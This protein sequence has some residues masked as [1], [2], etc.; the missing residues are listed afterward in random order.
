MTLE[1]KNP[2]TTLCLVRHGES[3]WNAEGRIQGQLDSS[4]SALGKNQ[5]E[6]VAQRLKNESWEAL[7]SSD[8][9]RARETAEVIK[10]NM[11]GFEIHMDPLLRERSFGKAE[12]LVRE[13]VT[14]RYPDFPDNTSEIGMETPEEL[15]ERA[16]KVFTGIR[17]AHLGERVIIVTHG[18]LIRTF[19]KSI[20]PDTE[21]VSLNNTS[22]TL[23]HWDGRGWECEYLGDASH[24]DGAANIKMFAPD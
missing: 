5:A 10:K 4:L 18:G 15:R 6:L 1:F 11:P 8:L 14:A 7:Y 17:D 2:V 24:L 13:E 12:G 21:K 9:S 20:F 16:V 22:C 23:L 19:I 3:V